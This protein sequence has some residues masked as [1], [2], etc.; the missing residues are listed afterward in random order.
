MGLD[1]LMLYTEDTYEV[2]SRPYFGYLRGRYSQSELSDLDCYA[3]KFGIEIIPCIQTLGHLEQVLKWEVMI[4]YRDT[5]DILLVD[6]EKTYELIEE[7]IVAAS[8][9]FRSKRIHIG[10]DE[11]YQ[12]GLGRY[13]SLH[14][15]ERRFEIMLRHLEKVVAIT[16]KYD[17]EP[18]IWSDM[19]FRLGSKTGDYYGLASQVPEDIAKRIPKGVRL[20]Y[21]D[22]YHKEK[23][24]YKEFIQRH[25]KL[26]S[27]PIFAGA[28]WY[29]YGFCPNYGKTFLSTNAALMACKE[30]KVQEVF[31]TIWNDDGSEKIL[32][33]SLLGLQL[34]AEHGY[35][36]D[37][38][39]PRLKERFEFC[40]Q[41][42]YDAFMALKYL[43]ETPGTQQD[44]WENYR[45]SK[46]LLWQDLL[47][48]LFDANV[49]GLP[50]NQHYSWLANQYG[51][52]KQDQKWS[53]FFNFYQ[54]LALVLAQKSELGN[55]ISDYYRTGKRSAL[56]EVV[57][58]DLPALQR[59]IHLLREA[60]RELW[61]ALYKPFGWEVL[62]IRYGGLLVRV[63]TVL[64]RLKDYLA[65]EIES[66]PE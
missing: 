19:F 15:Y 61:H 3:E 38:S 39:A 53:S 36:K 25:R 6:D 17:L 7:M 60:H 27:E 45:P 4:P 51:V 49:K 12:I 41:A 55:R 23:D 13:L 16:Q 43:D 24:F 33:S 50:L 30:E 34:F 35:N 64:W 63:D 56:E 29:G 18:M 59:Q 44:N 42:S 1:T 21:W 26:G 5:E 32:Y 8:R 22:Y 10:M 40:N 48:G 57:A 11:A 66:I 65:G 47:L 46:Y 20:V 28:I 62:D 9:P 31:A 54:N 58:K 2:P 37:V 14:G 52:Y